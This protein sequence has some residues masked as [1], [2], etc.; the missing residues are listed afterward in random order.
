MRPIDADML[1]EGVAE[2]AR[3][4]GDKENVEAMATGIIDAIGALPTIPIPN[5]PEINKRLRYN[6]EY[7]E[8]FAERHPEDK[9]L[10]KS[11][12][13]CFYA[14][15]RIAEDVPPLGMTMLEYINARMC[16]VAGSDESEVN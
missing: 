9:K 6:A 13:G 4:F 8:V 5:V 11:M 2:V 12:A 10:Y 1:L 14:A 15:I 7:Y 3:R 16:P